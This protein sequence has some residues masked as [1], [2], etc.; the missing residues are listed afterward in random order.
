M[1]KR[2]NIVLPD[3]TLRLLDKVAPRGNRSRL[4]SEAVRHYLTSRA[5]R[6]LAAR[7]KQGAMADA[8]RDLEIAQEWFSVDEEAWQPKRSAP[9]KT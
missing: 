9:G 5:R 4:I 6:N 3:E 1:T 2:I 7:M 8:Q